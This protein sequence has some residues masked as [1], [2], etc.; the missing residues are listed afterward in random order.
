MAAGAADPRQKVLMELVGWIND[1][2]EWF[3]TSWVGNAGAGGTQ[4]NGAAQGWDSLL[5]VPAAVLGV[6]LVTLCVCLGVQG[7]LPSEGTSRNSQGEK[8]SSWNLGIL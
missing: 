2:L 4:W 6:E 8:Q 3:L 5:S 7:K 1:P